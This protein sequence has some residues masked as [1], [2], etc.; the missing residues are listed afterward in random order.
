MVLR[1]GDSN[2]NVGKQIDGFETMHGE[3]RLGE[4]MWKKCCQNF[5]MKKN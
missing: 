2:E 3:N 4:K 1:L 5:A